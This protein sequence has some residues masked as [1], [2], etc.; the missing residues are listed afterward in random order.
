[1]GLIII[2]F[3][4]YKDKISNPMKDDMD[5]KKESNLGYQNQLGVFSNSHD[6]I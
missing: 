3:N 5:R 4:I 1:M 6:K 2:W